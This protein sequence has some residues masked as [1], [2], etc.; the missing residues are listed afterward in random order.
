MKQSR[1]GNLPERVHTALADRRGYKARARAFGII[2]P[3]ADGFRRR[4][5]DFAP[6]LRRTKLAALAENDR[7][8]ELAM[9]RMRENG[10]HVYRANTGEEAV[11]QALAILTGPGTVVK[12]KSNMG[13]EL[14]LPEAL[15]GQGLTV[16]E[17][18]L[19]DRINQLGGWH[20]AHILAPA[21]SVDRAQVRDLFARELGEEL[22]DDVDVLVAA[23]RKSL[24][25]YLMEAE[26]G[27]T[28][29]NA[30]AA[31]SGT[32]C[33]MENEGNI[34]MVSS[35]PR[36]H[37]VVA[38]I[39]KVVPSLTEAI[40]VIRGAS[41]FGAGQLFGNYLSC[42]SGPGDGIAGP[43][44]VHVIL[45]DGGRTQAMA[46]G[47]T[48]AFA[49]I[50]CGSCLNFC[51]IYT[52]IGDAFGGVR[53]GGIGTLMTALLDGSAAGDRDGAALCIGCGK[54]ATI[55]PV[56]LDTPHLLNRLKSEAGLAPAPRLAR[57]LLNAVKDPAM[58]RRVGRLVRSYQTSG[59]QGLVRSSGIL[60]PLGLADAEALLPPPVA[61]AALPDDW[62]AIGGER[63]AV[64]FF[65]GCL[66]DELLNPINRD[67]LAVLTK[68]G[69][70]VRTPGGQVCC[71]AMHEHSGERET[72]RQLAR[73]NID[74]FAGE[75]PII[76]NSGGCGALMKQYGE[77]LADD[78]AYAEKARA[79]AARVR[80]LSEYLVALGPRPMKGVIPV[81]VTYHE[82]CHLSLG[83]GISDQPRA[84]LK[85]I[86]GVELVEMAAR[87][88]CCG[89]GGTWSMQHPELAARLQE[90]KLEDAAAT[91]AEVL[92]TA[93][94]GCLLHLQSRGLRAVHLAE[95][96]AQAYGRK[97]V[98]E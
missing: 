67:T 81:K 54:C 89:S 83:Q 77:L 17:T 6:V 2:R 91:G 58:L 29:A 43:A 64:S 47:Y 12:S 7:L 25:R 4:F 60:K 88:A 70:R 59:L 50:N 61:P 71:G 82:S 94:P 34:R 41:M 69:C 65:R 79:F 14:H 16:I 31:E 49:C 52:E 57:M 45:V 90:V 55:C 19:G 15:A 73:Q 38:G 1:H 37:V 84:L 68:N 56:Q 22:T 35:L 9:A 3:R 13:K 11:A 76:T 33:L 86:P 10:M 97:G 72:A 51:P 85:A 26:Y 96:L 63:D 30:I 92:V 32:V 66:M 21:A 44:E 74:A 27:L 18:D 5:P 36:V 53:V 80:D 46:A 93:N 28:G 78:P 40:S 95:L 42:I 24:R 75:G 62:P 98:A 23:A 39:H 48:E 8:V 87:E 20:G